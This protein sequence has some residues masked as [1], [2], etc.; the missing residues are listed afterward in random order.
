MRIALG[1][2]RREVLLLVAREGIGSS[3]AGILIGLLLSAVGGRLLGSL[4]FD[5]RP[6]DPLVFALVPVF[7][8]AVAAIASCAPALRAARVDP[9]LALRSE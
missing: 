6:L 1:A 3:A 5:V 4:L 9:I 7:L 8:L 2:G